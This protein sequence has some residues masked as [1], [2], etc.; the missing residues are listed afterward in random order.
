LR[1]SRRTNRYFRS[2]L[3]GPAQELHFA[4]G[5][6]V[7]LSSRQPLNETVARSAAA[8]MA[9]DLGRAG[10]PIRHA[11]SF[12]FD[13]AAVEWFRD[14]LMEAYSVRIAV[15]DLPT[16]QWDDLIMAIARRWLANLQSLGA[17]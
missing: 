1:N 2:A 11:G 6:Y 5:L 15:P 12:G 8:K 4:H 14:A 9:E 17:A 7:T 10:F 13:F 16:K 3:K